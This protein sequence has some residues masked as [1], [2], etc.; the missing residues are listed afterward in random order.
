MARGRGTYDLRRRIHGPLH[1]AMILTDKLNCL[2]NTN[3][4][5]RWDVHGRQPEPWMIHLITSG[6]HKGWYHVSIQRTL[7]QTFKR[8]ERYS[9]KVNLKPWRRREATLL[10]TGTSFGWN[11][12]QELTE[13]VMVTLDFCFSLNHLET[14]PATPAHWIRSWRF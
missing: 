6:G 12:E 13:E 5:V 3:E 8:G 10:A 14:L 9:R 11:R 7:H 4:R 2:Q 1:E